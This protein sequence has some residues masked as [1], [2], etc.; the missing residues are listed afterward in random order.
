MQTKYLAILAASILSLGLVAGCSNPPAETTNSPKDT[1][2]TEVAPTNSPKDTTDTEVAPTNSP[3]DTINTTADTTAH[4]VETAQSTPNKTS[5][6]ESIELRFY[7]ENGVAIRGTD[8]VAYFRQSQPVPG[9]SEYTYE[10]MNATWQFASAEN[11]DLFAKNP[12]KYAPQYGGFCAWAVSRGYTASTQP[13]A[14]K[15]V[16]GK[17]YLNFNRQV[18]RSW[19]KDI[20]GNIAKANSNWPGVLNEG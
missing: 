4:E 9:N 18:Q 5:T 19:E 3:K 13:D 8:P 11:R 10:W 2:D 17:L 12:E 16:D 14:W 20:S 7:T 6:D 15:I 1:T